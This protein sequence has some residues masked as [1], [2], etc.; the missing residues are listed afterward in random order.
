MPRPNFVGRLG[1]GKFR[2]C[3]WPTC[4]I[5]DKLN[6]AGVCQFSICFPAGSP[7]GGSPGSVS[8]VVNDVSEFDFSQFDCCNWAWWV[9]EVA[10]NWLLRG[11][12]SYFRQLFG[13]LSK[14]WLDIDRDELEVV[15]VVA[16]CPW[17]LLEF[18]CLSEAILGSDAE[19]EADG[20]GFLDEVVS[21]SAPAAGALC[22]LVSS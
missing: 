14:S 6:P 9:G 21:V 20:W 2:F 4:K 16:V 3:P 1:H 13:F 5:S 12:I 11:C 22:Q 15:L 17:L 19:F 7:F 8:L 18:A 10:T